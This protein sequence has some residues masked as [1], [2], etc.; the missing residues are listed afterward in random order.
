MAI[1]FDNTCFK[2]LIETYPDWCSFKHFIE[3]D[4]GG[5][6]HCSELD[7]QGLCIIHYEK[8]SSNMTLSHSQWFRSVVWNTVRHR[9]VSI[10]PPKA[11]TKELPFTTLHGA[12]DIICEE[13]LDGFMINCFRMIGDPSLHITTRSKLNATGHFYSSKSFRR[14]FIESYLNRSMESDAEAEDAIKDIDL[15][16]PCEAMNEFATCYSFLVQHVEH[17]IVTPIVQNRVHLIHNS[18]IYNDGM[19]ITRSCRDAVIPMV[20]ATNVD[21]VIKEWTQQLFQANSWEFQGIVWKDATGNRW[22]VRSEKYNAVK[23]LRGNSPHSAERFAQMYQQ[24]LIPTYL[25]YYPEDSIDFSF[26]TFLMSYMM[27]IIYDYYIARHVEHT[28]TTAEID[29]MYHSHLYAIHGLYL[30]KRELITP[31]I[32]QQYFHKQPWQRIVFMIKKHKALYFSQLA[33]VLQL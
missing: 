28:I 5:A 25:Q 21:D 31:L 9:P 33:R 23:S 27:S 11:C 3:S 7:E 16:T 22:R 24:N 32:I 1:T 19:V 17:R 18:I 13:L 8:G 12:G 2:D 10:A 15:S 30:L 14:L 20:S 29:K 26:Y 6:F 4:D